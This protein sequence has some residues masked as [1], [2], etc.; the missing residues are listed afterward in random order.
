[1]PTF[2]VYFSAIAI[3]AAISLAASAAP[4]GPQFMPL[5]EIEVGM[6]IVGKSCFRGVEIE[7]FTGEIVGIER[8]AFAGGDM[9]WADLKGPMLG[10]HSV[11]SGMSGSPV[12]IDGRMIGAVGYGFPGS[13]KPIGGITPI[14]QMLQ[15]LDRVN[16]QPHPYE[17]ELDDG[18]AT[19]GIWDIEELRTM[20]LNSH[21][22]GNR[23]LCGLMWIVFRRNCAKMF[24]QAPI[25]WRSDRFRWRWGFRAVHPKF[26][27]R[28]GI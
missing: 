13:Q 27:L 4:L 14:E 10:A 8:G 11:A 16:D 15:V 7:E 12:Y 6:Q 22:G 9:I 23:R 2:R 21:P 5:S 18:A 25:A 28:C 24:P 1:L 26:S 17:N 19:V 3:W 20:A